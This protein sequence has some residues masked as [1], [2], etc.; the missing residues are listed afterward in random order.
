MNILISANNYPTPDYPL[1]AFIGVLCRELSVQGHHVTVVAPISVLSYRKHHIKMMPYHYTEDVFTPDGIKQIHIYRPRMYVLGEGRFMKST[2]WIAQKVVSRCAK[3]INQ[4]FD[5]LYCHFWS[6]ALNV[7]D[8]V[9]K[10]AVPLFVA[11][12]EDVIQLNYLRNKKNVNFLRE[13]TRGVICVSSKNQE[14]SIAKELTDCSKCL[15]LP[16]AV[17]SKE[18]YPIDKIAVRKELGFPEDAFIVAFCGRFNDRKGAMRVSDAIKNCADSNIKSIFIGRT[19][20]GSNITPNCEGI[21]FKGTLSHDKIVKYLNA[22]DVYVLPTLAE[23]C[24]NSIV[25]A[26]ACGLPVIS[27]DLPFNYDILNRNNS[28]MLDPLNVK[29][30]ANAILKIKEDSLYARNLSE[31]ALEM[32]K[33]LTISNRVSRIVDFIKEKSK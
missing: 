26:L 30:I 31:G 15:V 33:D 3:T 1:Q 2:S 29:E 14:E 13:L 32:A 27:S 5:V 11:S 8:Y 7:L 20:E 4:R 22:A 19:V 16:N 25:E 24:S 12:G 21:L 23:G 10:T 18:F 9:Q 28:I 17:D 6:S